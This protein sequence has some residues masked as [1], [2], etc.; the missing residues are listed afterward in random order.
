MFGIIDWVLPL[1]GAVGKYVSWLLCVKKKHWYDLMWPMPF[2][3][4]A[5]SRRRFLG[6]VEPVEVFSALALLPL[7]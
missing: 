4:N 5:L 1:P 2:M 6:P 3:S 7:A